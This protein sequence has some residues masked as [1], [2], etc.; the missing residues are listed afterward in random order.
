MLV[1]WYLVAFEIIGKSGSVCN[2]SVFKAILVHQ[3]VHKAWWSRSAVW[4]DGVSLSITS[5]LIDKRNVVVSA[6]Q[7]T[8]HLC[9]NITRLQAAESSPLML[10][11]VNKVSGSLPPCDLWLKLV[12]LAMR[13]R[14]AQ[15]LFVAA[16]TCNRSVTRKTSQIFSAARSLHPLLTPVLVGWFGFSD[17]L[18]SCY[19][20]LTYKPP[21]VSP[22]KCFNGML[23]G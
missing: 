4:L 6:G 11:R 18:H 8:L 7:W 16:R 23:S 10:L 19:S 14:N 3:D 12:A 22:L 5:S 2:H 20:P 15:P 13:M 1:P 21:N 17:V 9:R